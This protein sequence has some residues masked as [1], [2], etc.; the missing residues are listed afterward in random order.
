VPH[1]IAAFRA[2]RLGNAGGVRSAGVDP[3]QSLG[4]HMPKPADSSPPTTLA[5]V[6]QRI[7]AAARERE[8]MDAEPRSQALAA[9]R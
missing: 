1:T 6:E 7:V 2:F 5:D 9:R 8:G 3:V 4:V